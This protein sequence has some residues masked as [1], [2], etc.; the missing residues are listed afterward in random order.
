[1]KNFGVYHYISNGAKS[2]SAVNSPLDLLLNLA[3]SKDSQFN[4]SQIPTNKTEETVT[5]EKTEK[6]S[7][8]EYDIKTK[9]D[10]PLFPEPKV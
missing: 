10:I 5:S 8:K 6:F 1:M 9:T 7:Q 3:A 4:D 2:R